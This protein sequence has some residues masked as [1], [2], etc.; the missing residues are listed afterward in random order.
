MILLLV[1]A[2]V[3]VGMLLITAAA[4]DM[5]ARGRDG[6][7]YGLL[8]LLLPIGLV[9]WLIGRARYPRVAQ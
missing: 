2:V 5:D 6:R 3:L 9:V 4:R 1:T 7:W 8:M